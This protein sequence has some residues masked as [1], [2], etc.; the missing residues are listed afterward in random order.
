MGGCPAA[1]SLD[2]EPVPLVGS[3]SN[4]ACPALSVLTFFHAC[5]MF[6]GVGLFQDSGLNEAFV[7]LYPTRKYA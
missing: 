6:A 3:L 1:K 2:C 7:N 5:W 4:H